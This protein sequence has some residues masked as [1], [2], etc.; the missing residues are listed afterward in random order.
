MVPRARRIVAALIPL[1]PLLVL[2]LGPAV[3]DGA[4]RWP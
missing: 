2:V 1:L 3:A 4:K